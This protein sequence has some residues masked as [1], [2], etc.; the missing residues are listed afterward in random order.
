MSFVQSS[1]SAYFEAQDSRKLI[2]FPTPD[3]SSLILFVIHIVSIAL[4]VRS[5][6]QQQFVYGTF[7]FI[8]RFALS[9]SSLVTLSEWYVETPPSLNPRPAVLKSGPA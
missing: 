3:Y 1:N 7:S 4:R 8:Y 2:N 9:L 6:L 5:N